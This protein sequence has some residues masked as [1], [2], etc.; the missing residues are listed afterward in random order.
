MACTA[1]SPTTSARMPRAAETVT[2]PKPQRNVVR[3]VR[4]ADQPRARASAANGTQ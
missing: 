3:A 2:W 1:F 4:A